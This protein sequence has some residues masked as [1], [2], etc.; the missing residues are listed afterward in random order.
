MP[1]RSATSFH[2]ASES[3]AAFS[4]SA[5]AAGSALARLSALA[6]GRG[7][8]GASPGSAPLP[9]RGLRGRPRGRLGLSGRARLALGRLGG[10]HL[11]DDL[12]QGRAGDGGDQTAQRSH[13]LG[14]PKI[15]GRSRL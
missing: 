6:G 12:G 2:G 15:A 8:A 11:E 7:V 3:A 10:E 13:V 14:S 1:S 5:F 9:A 4:Q